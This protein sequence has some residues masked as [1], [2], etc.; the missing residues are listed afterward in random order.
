[1]G[2]I[3]C[4]CIDMA[5][6]LRGF[7][8][9]AGVVAASLLSACAS[10]PS[11]HANGADETSRPGTAGLRIATTHPNVLAAGERLV[12]AREQETIARADLLPEANLTASEIA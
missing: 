4:E 1:M 9:L 3:E 11:R 5:A 6:N 12:Q 8:M 7:W 10:A 2:W